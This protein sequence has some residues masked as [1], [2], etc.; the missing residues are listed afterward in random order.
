MHFNAFSDAAGFPK[1]RVR[2]AIGPDARAIG[3][4]ARAIGYQRSCELSA[5]ADFGCT[6]S[7]LRKK[8][9]LALVPVHDQQTRSG[10][11]Q[12]VPSDG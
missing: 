12:S 4:D 9:G 11:G 7:S 6:D 10:A 2:R 1:V 5:S 3:P 8:P